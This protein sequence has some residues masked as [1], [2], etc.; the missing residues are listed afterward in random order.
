MGVLGLLEETDTDT[1]TDPDSDAGTGAGAVARA[2]ARAASPADISDIDPAPP[3]LP[4]PGLPPLLPPAAPV[5]DGFSLESAG[6]ALVLMH[7][8]GANLET[9]GL[10]AARRVLQCMALKLKLGL[11]LGEEGGLSAA[12]QRALAA[13]AAEV[14]LAEGGDGDREGGTQ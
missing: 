7:R 14:R 9:L 6:A 12:E 2:R 5:A 4:V 10:K 3:A 8:M 11:G 1:D 13:L